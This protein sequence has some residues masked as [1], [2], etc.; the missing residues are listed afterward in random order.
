V[1]GL[2]VTISISSSPEQNPPSLRPSPLDRGALEIILWRE[3]IT[4]KDRIWGS[5]KLTDR[6]LREISGIEDI[7]DMSGLE[8]YSGQMENKEQILRS[9]E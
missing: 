6:E 9:S 1:P 4:D 3:A 8:E 7:R 5:D 2:V